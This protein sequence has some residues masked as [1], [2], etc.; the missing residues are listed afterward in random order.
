MSV[1]DGRLMAVAVAAAAEAG[2]RASPNPTVGA[3]VSRPDGTVVA[4]GVTEPVGG[5]HAEVVA[6]HAAGDA[7]RGSTLHVTLEPCAHHGRTPPCVDAV[8]AAG[9]GRVVVAL[10]DPDRR[11]AGAGIA[12]LQAAGIE[13]VVGPGADAARRLHRMYLTWRNTGRPFTTLKFASSL[14]GRVATATGE[15]QWITG[16]EARAVAHRMRAAHDAVMVG[17]GTVLADDPELGARPPGGAGRQPLRVIVDSRLRTPVGGRLLNAGSGAG[18]VLVVAA[19]GADTGRR[20]AL[21]AAGATVLEVDAADGRVDLRALLVELGRRDVSSVFAEG[22][23]TVLGSLVDTGLVDGVAAFLSPRLLGGEGARAAV[24][25]EGVS[26]LTEA[27][28]L[29]DVE[30]AFAGGDLVVTGYSEP[31]TGS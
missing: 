2:L 26:R 25:G 27:R 6:L 10:T 28:P 30:V 16:P 7:A 15:S 9:V 3:V 23:P 8:M 20:R 13:V 4:T 24:A 1:D 29:V 31:N 17:I 14:D 22:G 19:P 5:A 18:P 21:E 11:T 12:R